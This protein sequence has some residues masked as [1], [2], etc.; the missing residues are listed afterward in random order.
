MAG[1]RLGSGLDSGI[2]KP[3]CVDVGN[4]LRMRWRN[5]WLEHSDRA[6][7]ESI[8]LAGSD[9]H[10]VPVDPWQDVDKEFGVVGDVILLKL[11]ILVVKREAEG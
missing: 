1:G 8:Y 10:S 11:C 4:Q 7:I 3:S 9:L 5:C 2:V 6:T